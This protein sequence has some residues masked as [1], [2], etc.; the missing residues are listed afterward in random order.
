MTEAI[1]NLEFVKKR[2]YVMGGEMHGHSVDIEFVD[3][4][5][6]TINGEEYSCVRTKTGQP[7]LV[8]KDMTVENLFTT[9][10]SFF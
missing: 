8:H 2:V 1:T 10:L 7:L 4:V 3:G 5:V 6:H 9:T